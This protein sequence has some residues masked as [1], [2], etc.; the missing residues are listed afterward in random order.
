MAKTILHSFLRHCVYCRCMLP[1]EDLQGSSSRRGRAGSGDV[2]GAGA[3]DVISW[4]RRS[5]RPGPGVAIYT[6]LRVSQ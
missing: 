4:R 2:T 5:A 1:L 3:L 6:P